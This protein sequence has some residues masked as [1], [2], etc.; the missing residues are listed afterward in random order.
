MDQFLNIHDNINSFT[1]NSDK[2]VFSTIVVLINI[3]VVLKYYSSFDKYCS[4]FETSQRC[5]ILAFT[6]YSFPTP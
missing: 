4:S 3:V 5:W 6:L 1:V 2:V